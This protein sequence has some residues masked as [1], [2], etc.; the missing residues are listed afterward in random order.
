M[1]SNL[2]E[3]DRL[4]D[5]QRAFV[6]NFVPAR[7]KLS[8]IVAAP[9]TGKTLAAIIAAKECI[10]RGLVDG[11]LV[12]SFHRALA[13]NWMKALQSSGMDVCTP[14]DDRVG[15]SQS[16]VTTF[17]TLGAA[18]AAIQPSQKRY[19]LIVEEFHDADIDI[20]PLVHQILSANE[21]SRALFLSSI[22]RRPEL[23]LDAFRV[24]SEYFFDQPI[25]AAK[26]TRIEIARFSPSHEI[27]QA[28][29][30]RSTSIEELSWRNFERLIAELLNAEGY[31]VELMAGSKDGG[32]DV[33]AVMDR[34]PLGAFK[35]L[36]QAKKS[37]VGKKVGLRVVRELADTK[38]ELGAS[39][40]FIV[41][42]TYLTRDAIQRIDRDRYVLG[43]VDRGDLDLWIA[44][45]LLK[46]H[47]A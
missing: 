18:V 1:A 8:R 23:G 13:E 37:G 20:P 41:T 39:K 36:W 15:Q 35:T 26:E 28:L 7:A 12:A 5:R 16:V 22:A 11:L 46:K 3:I 43:K 32:V 31:K 33:I 40:A 2:P 30:R 27:L 38:N 9:G 10:H 6:S 44:S 25:F 47:G 24:E 14:E 42:S 34:G 45:V 29:L 19:L 21:S 4:S 17:K